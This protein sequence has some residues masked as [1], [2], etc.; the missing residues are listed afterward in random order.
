MLFFKNRKAKIVPL[1]F[2]RKA[3][4]ASASV[5]KSKNTIHFITEI[6]ITKVFRE[7][8][9]LKRDGRHIS[10]TTFL[11]KAFA[12]T[13]KKHRWMNSF[14]S[15]GKH[16]FLDDITISILMER[17]ING[18][19]VPEPM[20][21]HEVDKKTPWEIAHEISIAKNKCNNGKSLGD[22]SDAWYLKFIPGCLLK[23]FIRMADQNITMGI[24]YGKLAITSVGMFSTRPV[25]IIPHGSATILLSVGTTSFENIE[26]EVRKLHLTVSFDHDIVDGAPAARF[27]EDLCIEIEEAKC[28]H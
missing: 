27:I 10:M 5:S 9:N 20:V 8:E 18:V 23:S 13:V 4:R 25:W 11:A 12:L 19:S 2:L 6:D 28:I 24:K 15:H 22:L 26:Q 17:E 3:V 14:I 1:S 7:M 21:I 16:V